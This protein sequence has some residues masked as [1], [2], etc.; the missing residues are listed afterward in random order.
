MSYNI[1]V[2]T[3]ATIEIEKSTEETQATLAVDVASSVIC[4]DYRDYG[5]SC[6]QYL[7]IKG[8]QVSQ[9]NA[10]DLQPNYFG[11]P[12]HG[13]V[14]IFRYPNIAHASFVEEVY[15]S[16]FLVSEWNYYEGRYS[17]R[18]IMKDDPALIGFIHFIGSSQSPI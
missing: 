2:V 7:K 9:Q 11:S 4:A 12:F 5:C 3:P 17:E 13:D 8:I 15:I 14:A 6:M 16:S 10:S 1:E 18:V